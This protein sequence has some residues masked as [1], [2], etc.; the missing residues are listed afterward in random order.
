MKQ[1][2]HPKDSKTNWKGA[3]V[4]IDPELSGADDDG[5]YYDAHN[6]RV[7]STRGNKRSL[8]K[9]RGE[10]VKFVPNANT[11][12]DWYC[13]GD[14]SVN[15]KIIE[16]H[17]DQTNSQDPLIRIDGVIVG[18]SPAM[19]WLREFPLQLDRNENCLGGEIF[20]T[21]FNTPPMILNVDDMLDSLINDPNKYFSD[22]NPALYT[23][24]LNAPLDIPVFME[25]V[26]L[27]GGGGL[28]VGQ[29]QYS[30]RFV[31]DEGDRTN[32]GPL[33]PPIPV[34]QGLSASSSEY[35]NT[36]TYGDDANITAPTSFGV[37]LRFRITNLVNYDSVEIRR[38]D[39]NVEAG[40]N[41]VPQGIIIA[42]LAISDGEI[43]IREFIDPVQSNI[44]DTLADNEETSQ[45]FFIDKAKGI[46]YH[47]K[48]VVLMNVET[49]SKE[50]AAGFI[51][52]NGKKIFP[53]VQAI[54]KAGHNDPVN[55]AYYRSYMGGERFSFA[56][57]L[58]DG[59][60]GRGFAFDDPALKNFE[61]PNR[62]DELDAD[63]QQLSYFGSATAANVQS[64]VTKTNEIFD[65]EDA[66]DK[67]EQCT[68]KNIMNDDGFLINF[69]AGKPRSAVNSL[70]CPDPDVGS[71]VQGSE[72]GYHPYKPTDANDS[73]DDHNYK[74]NVKVDKGSGDVDYNPDAFAPNYYSHGVAVSGLGNL[75]PWAKSFSINRSEAAG[76]VVCQ[77][78]GMYSLNEGDFNLIGNAST[79]NKDADKF[80]FFSPDIKAGLVNQGILDDIQ[81][82]P[83]NYSVQLVSPLGF[84]SEMYSF[85]NNTAFPDRDRLVDMITYARVLHDEGQVNPGEL[86][87]MGIPDGGDRHVAY[88]KYRNTSDAAGG[89]AFAVP[90]GG[91]KLIGVNGLTSITEGRGTYFQLDL[92]ESIYNTQ[93]TGGTGSN[94]FEDTGLQ[95]FT[96]PMYIVNIVQDGRNVIDRN[97]DQYYG[98]GHYQ[99]VESII[100]QGDGSANQ[101][102]ELVDER[103]EDCIPDL[104]STGPLATDETFVYIEKPNG[105]VDV[106]M[107]VTFL[108]PVQATVI[109]TNIAN[110]GFHLATT[111]AQ[112]V[113]VYTHTNTANKTF[114]IEFNIPNF[115]PQSD[116][117]VLV[118][119]DN[120]RPLRVFGGD[121]TVGETIFAPIDREAD[122]DANERNTQFTMN[123][124]F[125]F[126]KYEM[127]PRHYVIARTTG[128]NKIQDAVT[129]SLGFIR[130][131]CI[132]F[133]CESRIA[134]HYAHNNT[135]SNQYFPLTHYVMRPNR[136]DDSS[137]ADSDPA[138]IASDNNM[139]EEYFEDYP[140][141]YSIWK[142]GGL[143]FL[144]ETN[145]DYSVPGPIEFFSKPDFGF[146]EQNKFCTAVVWSLSRAINQQDSPGLK[147]FLSS[148]RFDIDDDNGEI[149]KAWDSRMG[150]KGENLY[151]ICASGICLL[152][153]KKAILSN[154]N[155]NDLTVT[156]TDAFINAQYWIDHAI[157]SNDEMWRGMGDA[158][159]DQVTERGRVKGEG[160]YIPNAHSVYLLTNNQVK[161]LTKD[162]YFNRINPV[163]QRIR[164]GYQDHVTGGFDENHNEY[165]LQLDPRTVGANQILGIHIPS[166]IDSH[167]FAFA[168]DTNRWV[169]TFGYNYD[170]YIFV[171]NEMYGIRDLETFTLDKGFIMNGKTIE[172]YMIQNYSPSPA[173]EK[174]LI[175]L[176]AMTGIRGEAKPSRVEILDE[177][178]NTLC[179]MDPSLQGSRYLKQYDG[180]GQFV[181]RMDS[182]ASP[183][184]DRVQRRLFF[185]KYIHT[186]DEDFKIIDTV[187][188]FK[189]IK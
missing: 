136:F 81:N 148:N 165:W 27:G 22:F 114:T 42:R 68:F 11:P 102:F 120:R 33:T 140:D 3:N 21:D 19:P 147:T 1:E 110:N 80:W 7:S 97:I 37:K 139:F 92:S 101:S 168:Q 151:A 74:V 95:S 87:G 123:I 116:E 133:A 160:L 71:F 79:A 76:R 182:V 111:G 41:F 122:G 31:N 188:Q 186:F 46:R 144:Q 98:T 109:L 55:H 134:T 162:T 177:N 106:F 174:E 5:E 25:L 135:L 4:N 38:I 153:T 89:G 6:G 167:L 52:F 150:G 12:G 179:A 64:S 18:Q 26:S 170:Q 45:L 93:F 65:L 69:Q 113:G 54:G 149:K 173:I 67:T 85:E 175:W 178:G 154:I 166:V 83:Q 142:F 57:T 63:S 13:I 118:R 48:K 56:A 36:K 158:S 169:G 82:N 40:I 86:A 94:D 155:A 145:V 117:K 73:T 108:T 171:D 59:L 141:E 50:S 77:G 16:L 35:P 180:W 164:S 184:R 34:V 8:E 84:F 163:L 9:I 138:A 29:Y 132:M 90:A 43:S 15:G 157:G 172:F 185:C 44:E 189:P 32:W 2:N 78:I 161:D 181:P 14:V 61:M 129:G 105:L 137:F 39:Y 30:L 20:I 91:N 112:V 96:E 143:R 121:T 28:P 130:Q 152:L 128:A 104:T 62:R 88:N 100:G 75:P 24:N 10:E 183:T 176:E 126:R 53:I 103:W 99:K 125:P 66:K 131:M 156:A 187:I 47:D 23:I 49:A 107:D 58:Y 115:Y 72:I 17:V 127:N 159:L 124:G 119:Y 51:D 146:E 60:G 70:G